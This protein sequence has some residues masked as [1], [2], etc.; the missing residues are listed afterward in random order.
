MSQK[1]KFWIGKPRGEQKI[2]L[3]WHTIYIDKFDVNGTNAILEGILNLNIKSSWT[4]HNPLCSLNAKPIPQFERTQF[5]LVFQITH[6][7]EYQINDKH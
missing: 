4:V 5:F 7:M 1:V 3:D 2:M 6:L